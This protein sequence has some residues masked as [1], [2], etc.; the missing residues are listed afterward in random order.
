MFEKRGRKG[1][2]TCSLEHCVR[3]VL[4]CGVL[5]FLVGLFFAC[6]LSVIWMSCAGILTVYILKY[7]SH[8]YYKAFFIVV[9]EGRSPHSSWVYI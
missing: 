4:D 2:V 6:F 1:E 7:G 9:G 3:K 5:L 8:G